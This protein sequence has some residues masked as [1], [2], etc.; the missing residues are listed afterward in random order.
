M[1]PVSQTTERVG[2]GRC[3]LTGL[4]TAKQYTG[5]INTAISYL[6]LPR[7][8][9]TPQK[10][11]ACHAASGIHGAKARL[12]AL[13]LGCFSTITINI[14]FDHSVP[15]SRKIVDQFIARAA[16]IERQ[17]PREDHLIFII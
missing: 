10:D 5:S 8:R 4:K 7:R 12:F 6:G 17:A 3:D 16:I 15:A 1:E 14:L 13:K 9:R 2:V 11:G